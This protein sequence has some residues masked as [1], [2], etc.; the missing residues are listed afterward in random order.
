MAQTRIDFVGG[1]CR[2]TCRCPTGVENASR[3]RLPE[4]ESPALP[5]E[6]DTRKQ[7]ARASRRRSKSCEVLDRRGALSMST[8]PECLLGEHVRASNLRRLAGKAI[9]SVWRSFS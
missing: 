6:P 9:A 8:T 4:D 7:W 1:G 5:R 2:V 3:R